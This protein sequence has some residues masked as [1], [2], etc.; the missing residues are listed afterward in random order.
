[1]SSTILGKVKKT[2]DRPELFNLV[3]F[4]I[5]GTQNVTRRLIRE[6]LQLKP[7]EKLLDVCCG[8]GEFADVALSEY[9]GIDINEQYIEYANRKYGAQGG[10]PERTFVAQDITS[11]KFAQEYGTFPK[12]MLIN[13]MHHLNDADNA[14]ILAAIAAVTTGRFVIVDMNPTPAN[15]I[16]K[17]LADQD[18]G[19][20][21][22][23]LK[24]QVAL[25][26]Q[27]FKVEKAFEYYSGLC[28][29]TIIVCSK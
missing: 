10:H 28:A 6:G 17:F 8:T 11:V 5:A 21:L 14:K 23:P 1:M 26:E 7:G 22:R 27:H 13:S 15:P 3:Q 4:A 18:R 16:S 9:V 19:D 24:A 20:Y 25:T 12:S 2:L 29:Q